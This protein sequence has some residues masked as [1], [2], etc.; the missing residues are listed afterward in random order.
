MQINNSF[1]TNYNAQSVRKSK[2]NNEPS[3]EGSKDYQKLFAEKVNELSEK[4]KNG[5]TETTI[6][7]GAQSYTEKEWNELLKKFDSTEENMRKLMR[8][9]QEAKEEEQVKN[10]QLTTKEANK[11]ILKKLT[12]S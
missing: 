7:T 12:N 9:S 2:S 10:E 5:D 4:I 11:V 1:S 8:E 3:E 6:Q